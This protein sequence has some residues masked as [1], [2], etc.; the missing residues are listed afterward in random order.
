MDSSNSMKEGGSSARPPLQDGLNYR[1]W[2]AEMKV[3]IKSI[4]E[5]ASK[6]ILIGWSPLT[7]ENAKGEMILK[8]KVHRTAEENKMSILTPKL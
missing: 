3:F 1:N 6:S 4:D 5:H 8:D 2:K 7:I